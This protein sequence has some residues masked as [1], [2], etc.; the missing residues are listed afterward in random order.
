MCQYG[1]RCYNNEKSKIKIFK[2]MTKIISG[3]IKIIRFF[4]LSSYLSGT[5]FMS[6]IIVM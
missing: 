6:T 1:T 3:K 5:T 2:E 4:S